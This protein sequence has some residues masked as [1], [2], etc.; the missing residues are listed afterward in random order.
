MATHV[1]AC[2]TIRL[3][4]NPNFP[5]RGIPLAS[6]HFYKLPLTI[7]GD[8]GDT[9]HLTG[10]DGEREVSDRRLATIVERTQPCDLEPG[11]AQCARTGGLNRQFLGP[12]HRA[13]HHIRRK[14]LDAAFS[15][16]RAPPQDGYL[17]GEL[18]HF[19]KLVS[20]HQDGDITLDDH[21]A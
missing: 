11:R 12:D 20:D 1:V 17:V 8:A 14:V 10:M 16:K 6:Q 2:R 9:D 21:V 5:T 4:A 15:Y 3:A 13:S 19:A 7:T 18:H